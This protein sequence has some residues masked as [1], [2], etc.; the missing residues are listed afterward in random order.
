MK[1]SIHLHIFMIYDK[2][3]MAHMEFITIKFI[4]NDEIRLSILILPYQFFIF[5]CKI[6]NGIFRSTCG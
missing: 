6:L 4:Y 1:Q 3:K 2:R 5:G